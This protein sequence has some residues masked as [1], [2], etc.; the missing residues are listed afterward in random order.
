MTKVK[1]SKSLIAS[2]VHRAYIDRR[3]SCIAISGLASH[4]FGSWKER[5]DSN[6]MWLR[7]QLPID[8]PYL[9]SIIYGYD[10][11]LIKSQSFQSID[12][13]ALAFFSRLRSITGPNARARSLVFFAHSLGGIVLKRAIAYAANSG[14]AE[15]DVLNNVRIIFFFGVPNQG[16]YMSHLL[17]MVGD[18]PNEG[19]VKEL[20]KNSDYLSML[21][22]QFSGLAVFRATRFI[23][24]YE[25]KRSRTT[26]VPCC[27]KLE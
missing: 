26:K 14:Q 18:Q 7:D 6:F 8:I 25:T 13:L 3:Q 27:T 24:V 12:D 20:S 15:G 2:N 21:D 10:T 1:S 19:L 22:I 4:A 9:R 16:M 17:A 5:G 23:S 11:S